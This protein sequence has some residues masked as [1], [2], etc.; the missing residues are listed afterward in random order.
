MDVNENFDVH[1]CDSVSQSVLAEEA[2][3]N[4][5]ENGAITKDEIALKKSKA[6]IC[7]KKVV[8]SVKKVYSVGYFKQF[9]TWEYTTQQRNTHK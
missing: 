4:C 8:R 5:F 2:E 3:W 7:V 9:C 6:Y 1:L